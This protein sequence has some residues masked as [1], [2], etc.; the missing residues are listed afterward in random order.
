MEELPET[1]WSALERA[2][3]ILSL[4]SYTKEEIDKILTIPWMADFLVNSIS[5][6]V[7]LA[8]SASNKKFIKVSNRETP[9]FL[10]NDALESMKTQIGEF[11]DSEIQKILANCPKYKPWQQIITQAITKWNNS[12]P[13]QSLYKYDSLCWG[14]KYPWR[15]WRSQ[16]G[17][18]TVGDACRVFWISLPQNMITVKKSNKT[19][20]S[21]IPDLS[22]D[23]A[24]PAT[25][26]NIP[27]NKIPF[28][29]TPWESVE[30]K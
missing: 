1:Q 5:W 20:I 18:N 19:Q 2:K 30:T 6:L 17:I 29:Y 27:D 4:C 16:Y 14:L 8:L 22:Q 26:P 13:I 15:Q 24:H 28:P 25:S 9:V 10:D 11:L 21:H 7:G 23:R 12:N 3:G